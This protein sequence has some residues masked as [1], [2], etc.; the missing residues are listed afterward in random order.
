V[1]DGIQIPY[2]SLLGCPMMYPGDLVKKF[3]SEFDSENKELQ[4]V[5]F[6]D[7]YPDEE[8]ACLKAAEE[9]RN[10]WER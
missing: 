5:L 2:S 1:K 6:F 10:T 9:F 3:D 8:R 4:L 7:S